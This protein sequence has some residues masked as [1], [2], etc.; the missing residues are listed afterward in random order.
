MTYQIE[1]MTAGRAMSMRRTGPYGPGN[2]ALMETFKEWVRANDLFT[3]SAVIL[4]ISQDHPQTTHRRNAA[5]T[6][7]AFWFLTTI[8]KR[9]RPLLNSPCQA[10]NTRSFPSPT[11]QRRFKKR[12]TTSFRSLPP[13]G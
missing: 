10:A 7:F 12:G 13:M 8:S 2:H 1:E 6:T 9:T 11:P 5:A 3:D 4:G